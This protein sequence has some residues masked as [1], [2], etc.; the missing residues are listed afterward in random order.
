MNPAAIGPYQIQRE[1]GRG[2]M[3]VA[4]LAGASENNERR[5]AECLLLLL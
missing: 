4:S 1:L 5:H 2:G 3:G